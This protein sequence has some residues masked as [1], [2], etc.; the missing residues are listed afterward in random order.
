MKKKNKNLLFK[1]GVGVA[2]GFAAYTY[3]SKNKKSKIKG[4]YLLSS[5]C[6]DEVFF[7]YSVDSCISPEEAEKAALAAAQDKL[8]K[9]VAIVSASDNKALTVNIG[10]S[11]RHCFMFGAVSDDLSI[12][13]DTLLFYVDAL[14][15]EVFESEK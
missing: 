12:N 4:E 6:E 11:R 7:D 13:P 3:F 5:D 9:G 1:L 14:T 2:A 8:G 10:G 15:G